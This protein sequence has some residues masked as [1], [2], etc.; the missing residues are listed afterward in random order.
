MESS[1]FKTMLE[2]QERAYN[3]AMEMVMKQMKD[4][5]KQLEGK[6]SD[7]ATSL[8]FTQREVDDLKSQNKDHEKERKAAKL[9][10]DKLTEQVEKIKELEERIN[11]QGDYS[12]RKNVR[13]SGIEECDGSET[14]EQTATS[15]T[16][17]L[18]DKMQLPGLV[19]ERAHRVGPSRDAK[20]RTIVARFSRYCDRESVMR[21][22]SKLKGTNIFVNDDLCPAS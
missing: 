5:I 22:A 15:I 2:S 16:S 12:S 8:E 14:W 13:I 6:V 17:M 20:P 19:L 1:L 21:N 11:Y 10:T 9:E 3:T 4:H 18:Q 7:L